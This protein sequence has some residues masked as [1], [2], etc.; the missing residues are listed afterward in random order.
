M[1]DCLLQLQQLTSTHRYTLEEVSLHKKVIKLRLTFKSML[2]VFS[3]DLQALD[4]FITQMSAYMHLDLSQ[5]FYPWASISASKCIKLS[6]TRRYGIPQRQHTVVS[7]SRTHH[8][9]SSTASFS[10]SEEEHLGIQSPNDSVLLMSS[11]FGRALY[12]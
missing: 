11:S 9:C 10:I 12:G 2:E 3:D 1:S 6:K 8:R 7:A 4:S 5:Q